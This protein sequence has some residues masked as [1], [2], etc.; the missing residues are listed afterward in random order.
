VTSTSAR[1]ASP[2]GPGRGVGLISLVVALSVPAGCGGSSGTGRTDRLKPAE[3]EFLAGYGATTQ[4]KPVR[5]QAEQILDRR[6][7]NAH[8]FT[9]VEAPPSRSDAAD[10]QPYVLGV[11]PAGSE[12]LAVERRRQTGYHLFE[13]YRPAG[14]NVPPNDRYVATLSPARRARYA[15]A[16][17]GSP[18]QH[19]TVHTPTGGTYTY[20]TGGC[21]A[22]AQTELYGSPDA[23]VL[24][25]TMRE[26]LLTSVV[27]AT[28]R[29]PRIVAKQRDWSRCVSR[30]TGES[31][32]QPHDI[33][34]R[35]RAAYDASGATPAVHRRE[36]AYAVADTRCTFR[37]GLAGL[38]AQVLRERAD[39]LAGP[40]RR[41][42]LQSLE[43]ERR[44]TA[45][46]ERIVAAS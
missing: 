11:G 46:A 42:L 5:D 45:K 32:S 34:K 31:F 23:A 37:T 13:A 15:S 29:D 18:A 20:P 22:A 43:T 28:E 24:V 25:T 35:L 39:A 26:D 8:G 19:K 17:F 30:A 44:A 3:F 16:L 27:Q 40:T 2:A 10:S 9:Y 38:Y 14:A 6:C 36:I 4:G 1:R 12:A 7:M 41:L 33:V 21:V